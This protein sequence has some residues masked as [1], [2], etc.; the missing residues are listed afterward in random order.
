MKVETDKMDLK[1]GLDFYAHDFLSSFNWRKSLWH[2]LNLEVCNSDSRE[3]KHR[4]NSNS[5]KSSPK[6]PGWLCS[7]L[8]YQ[9]V[10]TTWWCL[11]NIVQETFQKSN[12][13]PE[14]IK[15][16]LVS[17]GGYLNSMWARDKKHNHSENSMI[18][19]SS[20][21]IPF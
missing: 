10:G 17:V 14:W 11:L 6:I 3:L 16:I 2:E 8:W 1:Y 5:F 21:E 4:E 19:T 9:L 20:S 15:A 12:M 18:I 7:T 13:V